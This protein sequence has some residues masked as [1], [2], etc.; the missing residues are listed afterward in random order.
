MI[1]SWKSIPYY[2]INPIYQISTLGRVKRITSD[3][4]R[5]IKPFRKHGY[6]YVGLCKNGKQ[7]HFRLNRLVAEAFIPNPDNLPA[8][9]HKDEDKTNNQVNNLEWC[10][11]KYNTNYG[12]RNQKISK[13][14]S[15][16]VIG[17]DDQGYEEY[18]NSMTEASNYIG[19]SSPSHIG[20]CCRGKR[21]TSGGLK[22]RFVE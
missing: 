19:V 1:E 21:K 14:V 18:F 9:N 12:T 2:D 16:A 17:Y 3:G 20:D 4:E 5:I 7:K 22:W 6:L 15:K 10:T 13:A 11:P 8:V